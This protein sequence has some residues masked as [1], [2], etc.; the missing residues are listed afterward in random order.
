MYTHNHLYG[1]LLK[2]NW[3]KMKRAG[4]MC[5]NAQFEHFISYINFHCHIYCQCP[6]IHINKPIPSIDVRLPRL[7]FMRSLPW[8]EWLKC[9]QCYLFNFNKY[10]QQHAEWAHAA[11]QVA[12][13]QHGIFLFIYSLYGWFERWYCCWWWRMAGGGWRNNGCINSAR[14]WIFSF[15]LVNKYEQKK[16][17]IQWLN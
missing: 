12:C 3:I 9:F 2:I 15:I 8:L 10:P 4:W 7:L 16:L 17:N 13:Y 5:V 14:H 11:M 6:A 1:L